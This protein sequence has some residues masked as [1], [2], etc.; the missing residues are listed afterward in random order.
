MKNYLP[1]L[2]ITGAD[3]QLGHAL[4]A[5]EN[6][7][8]YELIACNRAQL[9]ITQPAAIDE[10]IKKF[11]PDIII[12]TAAYTAVDKAE[13]ETE[14]AMQVNY[15]AVAKLA[16]I[17]QQHRIPIIHF[18]T[19]YVFDGNTHSAYKEDDKT[20]PLNV[21]GKSKCLGEEAVRQSCEQH[22]ILRISSVFSEYGNNFLK[23]ILRHA[24]EK[25]ELN[26]VADQFSCPT[27]AANIAGVVYE[28][29]NHLHS[30]GTYHYCDAPIVSWYKFA[31]VIIEHAKKYQTLS[32]EK[33]HAIAAHEYARAANRPAY[34]ALNCDKLERD[35][36]IATSGW[37]HSLDRICKELI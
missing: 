11:S 22:I 34:S 7:T 28:M 10:T 15:H 24:R 36:G 25:K 32:V 27:D 16:S 21:Y 23:T 2:L 35:Y 1:K 12:N 37:Q 6:A 19:D 14:T 3:G 4:R 30:S 33:I 5:H 20:N 13:Q 31:T 9:D 18:S 8:H 26:I 29:L 17:C